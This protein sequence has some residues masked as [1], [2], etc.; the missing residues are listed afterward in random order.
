MKLTIV[1]KKEPKN[2]MDNVIIE[3][4][5][6]CPN[7]CSG[8]C[9]ASKDGIHMTLEQFQ[10][11]IGK[12]PPINISIS[13]G[14]PFV[15]PF[16][17]EMMQA[18]KNRFNRKVNV[19]TSGVVKINIKEYEDL[20]D[21]LYITTK[22]ADLTYDSLWK[23]S[24]IKDA[25]ENVAKL[26]SD[27]KETTINK[28]LIFSADKVNYNEI[29]KISRLARDYNAKVHVTRFL[30]YNQISRKIALSNLQWEKFAS[31]VKLKLKLDNVDFVFP[32]IFCPIQKKKR[33][34]SYDLCIAGINRMKIGV[35]GSVNG[36][37]Y[38]GKQNNIGNILNEGFFEIQNK[39]EEWRKKYMFETT[40]KFFKKKNK[41]VGC[42]ALRQLM[43]EDQNL[44][45]V[46]I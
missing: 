42:I 29:S 23:D 31:L 37:I 17:K 12:L 25:K 13:G 38:L 33:T 36:C 1:L 43:T 10:T 20:I 6:A 24:L 40:G 35:D 2:K 19:V 15:N 46:R 11:I 34:F 9:Y 30:P 18:Y 7:K 28:I 5:Y 27:A 3:I 39:L 21:T 14:E 16:I 44:I 22:Y 41:L 32:T 4:T 26:L 45:Q 8:T